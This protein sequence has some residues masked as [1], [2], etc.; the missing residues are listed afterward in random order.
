MKK[1]KDRIVP[2]ADTDYGLRECDP[3]E[4][5]EAICAG[6]NIARSD[7]PVT[8]IHAMLVRAGHKI[9]LSMVRKI[10]KAQREHHAEIDRKIGYASK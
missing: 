10:V 2:P 8:A 6:D 5:V 4:Y 7:A 3:I 9:S 1:L